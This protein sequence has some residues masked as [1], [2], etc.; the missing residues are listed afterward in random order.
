MGEPRNQFTFYRSYYD[1]IQELPKEERADIVLAICGY[2]LYEAEPEGL[3]AVGSAFFK[4]ARPTL[5]SGRRKAENGK[6]GGSK[7]KANSK[8]T[9]SKREYDTEYEYD[10]EYEVE[11][12]ADALAEMVEEKKLKLFGGELGKKVIILSDRQIA[13]LLEKMGI[14]VFD[15]YVERL[16]NYIIDTGRKPT[17]HYATILKWWTEDSQI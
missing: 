5:D 11:A 9:T 15:H 3:S 16:A 4:L 17:N 6:K 12:D 7:P 13:A 1:A 14:D 2:G 10:N 8:Q